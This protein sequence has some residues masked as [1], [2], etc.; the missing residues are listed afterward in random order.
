M[1]KTDQKSFTRKQRP[2]MAA[3]ILFVMSTLA[4]PALA[5]DPQWEIML[6][7]VHGKVAVD[8]TDSD[9]IYVAAS[10]GASGYTDY[11][12]GMLKSTDGGQTWDYFEFLTEG[13]NMG[14]P[15]HILS[16]LLSTKVD[17]SLLQLS[18]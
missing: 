1:Q 10:S 16:K 8:P 14:S 5:Q 13:W 17:S 6:P 15:E 2:F 7:D 18:L 4:S 9:V 11:K 12:S 3:F